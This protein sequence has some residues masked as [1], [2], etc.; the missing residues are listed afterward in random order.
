[1]SLTDEAR[2]D[3]AWIA[4][5]RKRAIVRLRNGNLVTLVSWGTTQN[6]NRA[7]FESQCGKR[8]WTGKKADVVEIVHI[9]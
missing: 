4:A 3:L 9:P 1:M 7:R 5:A 6:K 8:R 2:A